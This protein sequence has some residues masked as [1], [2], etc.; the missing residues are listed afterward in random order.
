MSRQAGS[1]QTQKAQGKNTAPS[2]SQEIESARKIFGLLAAAKTDAERNLIL[3][4]LSA[5]SINLLRTVGN[6]LSKP[7]ALNDDRYVAMHYIDVDK[8]YKKK[9][10]MTAMV[11]FVYRMVDEYEPD[12]ISPDLVSEDSPEFTNRLN[13]K[14]INYKRDKPRV[15][16]QAALH[17]EM[18]LPESEQ[19]LVEIYKLRLNV[20]RAKKNIMRFDIRQIL[21]SIDEI[22]IR[23]TNAAE[24]TKGLDRLIEEVE[25]RIRDI[26][27]YQDTG[28]RGNLTDTDLRVPISRLE[29]NLERQ[30]EERAKLAAAQADIQASLDT[31]TKELAEKQEAELAI[32]TDIVDL[33][34]EFTQNEGIKKLM[35]AKKPLSVQ[36]AETWKSFRLDMDKTDLDEDE[37]R[38][39][40]QEVK[41][42]LGIKHT[43]EEKKDKFLDRLTKF[44][45]SIFR[46]NPDNHVVC[47]YIPSYDRT[48]RIKIQSQ[49][50]RI[51]WE[52]RVTA[53]RRNAETKYARSVIPPK[54]TMHRFTRYMENNY[55]ALRQATDDIYDITPGFEHAFAPLNIFSGKKETVERE[56]NNWK[57]KYTNEFDLDVFLLNVGN[58]TLVDSWEENRDRIDI[59]TE[60]SEVIKKIV[61]RS[62]ED[63]RQGKTLMEKRVKKG[64]TKNETF[65]QYIAARGDKMEKY[66]AKRVTVADG[67]IDRDEFRQ[68]DSR[69]PDEKNEIELAIHHLA[70]VRYGVRRFRANMERFN[71]NLKA[72]EPGEVETNVKSAKMVHKE[73]A[74]KRA[75]KGKK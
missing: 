75:A 10:I 12:H 28:N 33:K 47:G 8:E 19:N 39:L 60:K 43:K 32:K 52:D 40:V 44:L 15:V 64:S 24:S 13:A 56:F 67:E 42:E 63:A 30:Q 14:V 41:D 22:K 9:M 3:D 46:Y 73:K 50:D 37:Y 29:A 34:L 62:K 71:V 38:N 27:E 54:D 59:Y 48:N 31:F 18:N 45:D 70:P 4:N 74:E 72:N 35:T 7:I 5:D 58:W 16:L 51:A 25:Q 55:E 26:K 49:A 57:H 6:P 17:N 23:L 53:L 68:N 21:S 61:E 2:T 36:L 66:G 65:D 20:L 69:L 1:R 11:G